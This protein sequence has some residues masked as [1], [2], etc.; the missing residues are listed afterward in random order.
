MLL[1]DFNI[2]IIHQI[3]RLSYTNLLDLG[4]WCSLQSRMEKEHCQKRMDVYALAKWAMNTWNN[5]KYLTDVIN[6]VW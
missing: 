6:C 2:V 4:V 3:P 1:E 5:D